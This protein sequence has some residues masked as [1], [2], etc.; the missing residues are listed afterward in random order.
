MLERLRKRR[1]AAKDYASA[2]VCRNV[3]VHIHNK[4]EGQRFRIGHLTDQ[5]V[6]R[7]TSMELQKAAVSLVNEAEPDVVLLTGDFVCHSDHFLDDL[8]RVLSDI[9]APAFAVLGN[10]DHWNDAEGVKRALGRAN[11]EVL[12]NA[13]T[14]VKIRDQVLQLVG[15]DDAYTEHDDIA[16]ATRGMMK[17]VPTIGL[18]HIAE[19]AHDLWKHDV[20]LVLSGHTHAGQVTFA[21]L[22][23]L[24]LGK[25]AK[26]EYIHGLYRNDK[27]GRP[28]QYV[29]VG[30]GVGSAVIPFRFGEKG[31]REAT[32]FDVETRHFRLF[33]NNHCNRP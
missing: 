28:H 23:E 7:V 9:K 24:I 20:D 14:I 18:S 5:H 25:I 16:A 6:G 17:G 1:S 19:K 2:I 30:A 31:K 32:I 11:V 3:E 26:H 4:H 15:L 29:Y 13:N 21:R 8:T 33:E 10:H 27:K 12:Q 22:N